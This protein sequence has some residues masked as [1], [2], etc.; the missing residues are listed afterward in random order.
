MKLMQSMLAISLLAIATLSNAQ[1]VYTP[2]F[3]VQHT[4][5]AAESPVQIPA[6][7]S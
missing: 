5:I 1:V 6:E 7:Q 2:D 4:Q 3:P